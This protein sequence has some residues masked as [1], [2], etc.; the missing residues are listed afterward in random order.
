MQHFDGSTLRDINKRNLKEMS[1]PSLPH[2][3]GLGTRNE[4][5]D[6]SPNGTDLLLPLCLTRPHLAHHLTDREEI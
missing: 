1:A 5:I 6:V 4:N 3:P 2:R